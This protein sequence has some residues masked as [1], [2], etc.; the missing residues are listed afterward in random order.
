MAVKKQ[1]VEMYVADDGKAYDSLFIATVATVV[2]LHMEKVLE[3]ME[4]P[5]WPSRL[6]NESLLEY[7][8]RERKQEEYWRVSSEQRMLATTSTAFLLQNIDLVMP[9]LNNYIKL[10]KEKENA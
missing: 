5:S 8:E 3:G 7:R 1:N 6:P 2:H 4:E 10:S 9:I